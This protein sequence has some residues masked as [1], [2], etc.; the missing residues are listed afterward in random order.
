MERFLIA[1]L[2]FVCVSSAAN[3]QGL[4]GAEMPK[5]VFG[6]TERSSQEIASLNNELEQRKVLLTIGLIVPVVFLAY[7]LTRKKPS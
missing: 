2:L 7:K 3:A 5:E 6:R 4:P 1:L